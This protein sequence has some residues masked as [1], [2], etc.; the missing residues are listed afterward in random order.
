MYAPISGVFRWCSAFFAILILGCYNS[1]VYLWERLI[2]A[3]G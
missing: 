2:N 3:R 1:P